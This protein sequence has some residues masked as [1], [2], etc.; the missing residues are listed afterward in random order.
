MFKYFMKLKVAITYTIDAFDA[1]I[2]KL[3][4]SVNNGFALEN[5]NKAPCQFSCQ[6]NNKAP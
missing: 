4:G 3:S 2:K 5:A 6:N 1:A